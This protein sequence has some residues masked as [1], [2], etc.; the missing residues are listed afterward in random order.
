MVALPQANYF[1]KIT[2]YIY[3]LCV[4]LNNID[5]NSHKQSTS[6]C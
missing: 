5:N 3:F 4:Q 1:K 2:K 6:L